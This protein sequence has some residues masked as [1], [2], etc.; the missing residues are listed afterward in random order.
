MSDF[1]IDG[2]ENNGQ[3]NDALLESMDSDDIEV[4]NE[5]ISGVVSP[6]EPPIDLS[7]SDAS[8]ERVQNN[9]SKVNYFIFS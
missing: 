7:S 3:N 9:T 6:V 2:Q 5:P 1:D 4:P 8:E